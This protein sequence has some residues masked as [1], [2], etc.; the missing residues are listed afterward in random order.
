MSTRERGGLIKLIT[1]PAV[2]NMR[3]TSQFLVDLW[4]SHAIA[5]DYFCDAFR[6]LVRLERR[7]IHVSV[8]FNSP[9]HHHPSC[10]NQCRI[11]PSPLPIYIHPT[12]QPSLHQ[13]PG[14]E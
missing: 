5:H 3:S 1:C 9:Q 10:H 11:S 2:S 7:L 14:S 4:R 8:I 13:S 6:D 12:H